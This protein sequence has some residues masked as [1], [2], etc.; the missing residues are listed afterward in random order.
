MNLSHITSQTLRR[1]LTLT[2]RKDELISLVAEIETEISNVLGSATAPLVSAAG[3][4]SDSALSVVEPK[5]KK[6]RK[7]S[8]KSAGKKAGKGGMKS[9]ILG[10]LE[11]AGSQGMRVKDIAAALGKSVGNVSVWFSTTGKELTHKI[12]PGLYSVLGAKPVEAAA[13]PEAARKPAAKK[14]APKKAVAKKPAAKK[15][16]PLKKAA[17]PAKKSAP[18]A[19]AAKKAAAKAPAKKSGLSPAGRAKLSASMKAR[20][21]KRRAAQAASF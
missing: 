17:A 7:P 21:E 9:Q 12:S 6:A 16:A 14:A 18:K 13:A 8:R 5:A 3:R 2:E 1:V 15:P 19:P 4:I 11:Q 10:L 20:W